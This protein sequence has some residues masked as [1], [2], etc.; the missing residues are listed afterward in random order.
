VSDGRATRSDRAGASPERGR[1]HGPVVE[2]PVDDRCA[3]WIDVVP[4]ELPLE[5][6][7]RWATTDASGGVVAFLGVVR[8]HADGRTD[9]TH[10]TYEAYADE[11]KRRMA[12]IAAL[13]RARWPVVERLVL[14]HRVG[15]VALGEASV[16]V[17][18]S[19]PHRAEAFEA[20]R[21]GIDTLKETVPVWKL[22]HWADGSDFATATS[23]A[24]PVQ[25]PAVGRSS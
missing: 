9:V 16:L 4:D 8:D 12:E 17:V 7:S 13:T 23:D 18:A 22:E 2:P 19:S 3:E 1:Y 10:I 14:L 15:D 6:A 5:A 11:A 20:A 24:R 25:A 21:F